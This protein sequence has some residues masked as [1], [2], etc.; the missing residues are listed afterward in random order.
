MGKTIEV[1]PSAG[2]TPRTAP[3]WQYDYG[4][5]IHING[6]ELPASYKAEFSN[7]TRGDA[8]ATVQT[9]DEI[10]IPAQYLESGAAVYIWLVVV[11]E[12]SRT[13]EYALIVPVAARAKPTDEEPAP[14]EQTEIEQ[15]LSALN[16]AVSDVQEIADAI[17]DTINDAL[18][19][20][21]ESGE[22]DGEDGYTP[23]KGV[24]YFDGKDGIDG[25]DGKDGA[26]G[27]T[28]QKGIDYFDG[29]DGKDGK[30][31][32]DGADGQTGPAGKDGAPGTPGTDGTTFTPAVSA[33]GVIS[34]TNDGGKTNPQPMNI[35]GPQGNDG[36]SP[37]VSVA[38]ISG[39]HRVTVTDAN[40]TRSFDVM[41]GEDY[42][43]T[44]ADK[45]EIAQQAAA[46]VDVPTIATAAQVKAG[47]DAAH[48]LA[49]SVQDTAVFYAIAKAAGADMA[50]SS[51]P[52]G[53]YTDAAKVAIQKM[54]G[55]YEAPWELIREDTVTN[56]TEADIEVT[57][58]ENGQPFELTD[59]RIQFW[60]PTQD[61]QAGKGDY[62]KIKLYYGNDSVDNL[63]IG[64]WTQNAN[65]TGKG[66][67]A[68]LE[69]EGRLIT[70]VCSSNQPS[71]GRANL[72]GIVS[73][74]KSGGMFELPSSKR[75]YTRIVFTA[76]SGKANYVIYGRRKWN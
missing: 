22:F 58:D 49:P 35:K 60:L 41:D 18:E 3:V 30:D 71:G 59:I 44:S 12:E 51:N 70:K 13:T 19:A 31:G 29:E 28:P 68:L 27:Y 61:V 63:Y 62:G 76:V 72:A 14:E 73:L 36:A 46:E 6:I 15:T 43:L 47:T 20:A 67:Y 34:W 4:Q 9:T 39:G 7:T 32:K 50:S 1:Y 17:P 23:V 24:D 37:T 48:F 56:A 16:Q 21:K 66:G 69:Q 57:V 65:A 45:S 40:G 2:K 64:A 38:D 54:L 75:I 52:V 5:S 33:E 42:V 11:D 26:D 53:T 25:K 10:T 55:I 8:I 74:A